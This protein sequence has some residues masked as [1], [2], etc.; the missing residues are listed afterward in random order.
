MTAK[1]LC[2]GINRFANLPQASWLNGCVNDA[3]DMA[4]MLLKRPEFGAG[5]VTVL[6]DAE[7]TKA[8]VM[9]TLTKLVNDGD[10]DHIVF[11][12]SSHGTQVPDKNGDEKV[13]HVD[14][15][16]ACHDIKQSGRDW[17]RR[18]V[19]IDDELKKLFESV[20]RNVLV[21]VVLDTCHSGT[22]LK[23]I[24]FL[25]GRRPR[26]LPPP[27]PMGIR[28]L[29]PKSDPKGLQDEVRQ[30]PEATRP[31]LFAA[32]TA[33]QVAS[34]APFG[35]HYNGAFTYYFL[36]ALKGADRTR[37]DLLDIVG[38]SLAGADFTQR[39]QLE[40]AAKA[41]NVPFGARWG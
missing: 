8:K 1:A 31:V 39:P 18:T 4:A 38:K 11:S 28:A 32:C 25:P 37:S 5:D 3:E 36:N 21:E 30:V 17:D 33:R 35:N 29:E 34:D 15:A 27:T 12:F 6:L 26:F 9:A 24:D 20:R 13:D 41:K 16:F 19:I 10:V 2:V 23:S 40:A 7:A 22:G 14:E